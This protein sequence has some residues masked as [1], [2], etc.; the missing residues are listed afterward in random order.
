MN[1][2]QAVIPRGIADFVR[3]VAS[4]HGGEAA[5]HTVVSELAH[6]GQRRPQPDRARARL[7]ACAGVVVKI[8]P[9]G[10]DTALLRRRLQVITQPGAS[11]FWVQ[12]LHG[13]PILAPDGTTHHDLATSSRAGSRPPATVDAVGNPAC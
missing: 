7:Y 10:A 8:H 11:R 12:P 3:T 9:F 5:S 4:D 6:Q 13:I 2:I 1:E